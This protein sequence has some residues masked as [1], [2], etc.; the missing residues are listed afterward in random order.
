LFLLKNQGKRIKKKVSF[1]L[2]N[3]LSPS[4]LVTLLIPA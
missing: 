4:F 3:T 1:A 2:W